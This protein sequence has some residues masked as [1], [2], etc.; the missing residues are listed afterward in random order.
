MKKGVQLG[1]HCSKHFLYIPLSR[2]FLF[3]PPSSYSSVP[4]HLTITFYFSPLYIF[5]YFP[6]FL[7]TFLTI[8]WRLIYLHL[9][10]FMFFPLTHHYSVP[11]RPS[12][13][14]HSISFSCFIFFFDAS[15]IFFS[16]SSWVSP[17]LSSS[18]LCASF[19]S[20]FRAFL[21]NSS[22]CASAIHSFFSFYAS[23]LNISCTF[24]QFF[25]MGLSAFILLLLCFFFSVFLAR[26]LNSS[27]WVSTFILLFVCPFLFNISCTS[28]FYFV[29]L[30]SS[31]F[32]LCFVV[33]LSTYLVHFVMLTHLFLLFF[34]SLHSSVSSN[35]LFS[36]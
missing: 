3:L 23:F 20:I 5:F 15:S 35:P 18:S 1:K 27:S 13:H 14:L 28:Q 25:F 34:F 10:L 4:L 12:M 17:L 22:S 33:L 21:L 11:V 24:P 31:L 26:S 36:F 30:I 19:F 2:L 6:P 32:I 8:P 9:P 16:D 7:Y 29:S